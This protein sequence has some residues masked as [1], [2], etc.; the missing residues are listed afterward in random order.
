MTIA[1]ISFLEISFDLINPSSA[2]SGAFMI[3]DD[4]IRYMLHKIFSI[5][6]YDHI[7]AHMIKITRDAAL[8]IESD[9]SKSFIDKI[10]K[11]VKN[12][13]DGD[14]VRLV[15]DKTIDDETLNKLNIKFYI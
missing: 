7:S 4:L 14:P 8:D 12:R 11:S 5:F 2:I 3:L 15:Y 13:S 1:E 6:K 9:L 10:S